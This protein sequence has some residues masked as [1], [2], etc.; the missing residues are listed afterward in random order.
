MD[1]FNMMVRSVRVTAPCSTEDD[2]LLERG[3]KVD[4]V[5]RRHLHALDTELRELDGSFELEVF[6]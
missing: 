6:Q 1:R 5:V 4:E 2:V 3:P